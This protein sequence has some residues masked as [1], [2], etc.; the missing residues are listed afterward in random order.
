MTGLRDRQSKAEKT[1]IFCSDAMVG[2]FECAEL[3]RDALAHEDPQPFHLFL[4]DAA[5]AHEIT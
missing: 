4:L 2:R 3:K 1:F 5:L